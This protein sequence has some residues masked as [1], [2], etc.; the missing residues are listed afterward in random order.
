M[1]QTVMQKNIFFSIKRSTST[2]NYTRFSLG[3]KVSSVCR[4]VLNS[5]GAIIYK[6]MAFEAVPPSLPLLQN[7][8]TC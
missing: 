4:F 7:A 5:D 2:Q 3:F 1:G 8:K 6:R